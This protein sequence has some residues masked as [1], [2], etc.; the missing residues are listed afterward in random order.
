MKIL[1]DHNLP[2]LLAHGGFQIQIE[3]T[4]KALMQVGVQVEE[5]RWWDATQTGDIIHYFGRPSG[6]YIDFAHQKGF[7][8]VVGELHTGLG[9]RSDKQRLLQKIII[10]IS[11]KIVPRS[12]TSRLHWDAYAKADAFFALTNFEKTIMVEMFGAHKE[13]TYEVPNGVEDEFFS[14]QNHSGIEIPH[15]KYFVC[16]ATITER[17]RIFELAKAAVLAQVPVW[18]I[19]SPYSQEDPYYINFLNLQKRH[20]EIIIYKGAISDR[21]HLATAYRRSSG[22]VLYSLMES[23]S[24]SALEAAACQCRLLLA[25]YPW[26][27]STFGDKANYFKPDL[28][29]SQLADCLKKYYCNLESLVK[30]DLPKKWLEIGSIV[31]ANYQ[32]ILSR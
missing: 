25:D 20:P 18:F 11:K 26:A 14:D 12:F 23:Q 19:G 30:P 16:T 31:K 15:Q 29:P 3:Q 22:F 32:K 6:G 24:L 21:N 5:L 2:F 17:K 13:K 1:F 10:K 28:N 4:K 7:K 8:V 9:S 27:R